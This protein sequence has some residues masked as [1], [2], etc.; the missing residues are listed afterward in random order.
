MT[1]GDSKFR[2]WK[3]GGHGRTD[4]QKALRESCDV[5]FYK[6]GLETGIDRLSEM[7]FALGLGK[8]TGFPLEGEKSGLIPTRQWKKKRFGAPWY[9]GETV[10][11]A[12][13]QGYVLTTPLQLAVMTAAIANGGVVLQPTLIKKVENWQG[14]ELMASER[15][16]SRKVQLRPENLAAVRRGL[17][18]VV[19][20]PRGTGYNSRLEGIKVA[21]KTGTAQVVRLK[22]DEEKEKE[23]EGEEEPYRFRDHALFV[24]YAPA[25]APEIAVAVVVEHGGGGGS[26]AAPV[27]RN[28]LENYFSPVNEAPVGK[29]TVDGD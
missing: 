21:G 28:I 8:P 12:I 26:T 29:P 27:A 2:C 7:S 22:S 1:L 24:A 17:E 10:I 5:W 4:M 18:A 25:E 15:L 20:A 11:A 3:K 23:K 6:A 19:N 13:G 16:V 9:N 14:E